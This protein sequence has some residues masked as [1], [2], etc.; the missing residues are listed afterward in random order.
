MGEPIKI[1]VRCEC[2]YSEL[3]I[4]DSEDVEA[5]YREAMKCA[6][7]HKSKCEGS[8]FIVTRRNVLK[9]AMRVR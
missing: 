3:F 5:A 4:Y 6:L 2:G 8:V 7:Q 1:L 9:K